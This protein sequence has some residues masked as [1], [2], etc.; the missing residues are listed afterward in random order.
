MTNLDSRRARALQLIHSVALLVASSNPVAGSLFTAGMT[1][2]SGSLYALT[3]DTERFRFLALSRRWAACVS[4]PA[5]S[6][7]PLA[8]AVLA[9][10]GHVH[11]QEAGC[12][13]YL[14]VYDSRRLR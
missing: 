1:M 4:L 2:F 6:R 7:W 10:G 9:C 11:E 14:L 3:L 8:S 12:A 5:G 13:H